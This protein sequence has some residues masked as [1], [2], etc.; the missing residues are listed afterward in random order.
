M[1][2]LEEDNGLST[3]PMK[4]LNFSVAEL[5]TFCMS[6]VLGSAILSHMPIVVFTIFEMGDEKGCF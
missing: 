1:V 5:Y 2:L 4:L 3:A 6:I